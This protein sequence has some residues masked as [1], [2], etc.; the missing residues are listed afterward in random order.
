MINFAFLVLLGWAPL[1]LVL[2]LMLP[3]RRAVVV[4]AIAGSLL[5]PPLAIDFAGFPPYSKSVAFSV[6]I[7]LGTL[8]FEFDRLMRFRLRWF[9]L[10]M[11]LWCV[12]PSV[13]SITNGFGGLEPISTF[14]GQ[15][16]V[17]LFPYLIGR[18][19]FN[20]HD[21]VRELA[22][23][24]IIGA[25]CLIPACIFENRM[26]PLLLPMVYG[27]SSF[28]TGVRMGGYRPRVF[29]HT[30]LELGLWM[31]A[32]ALAAFW[33]WRNKQ[34][35]SIWVFSGT[36]IFLALFITA[37]LCRSAGATVLLFGGMTMLWICQRTRTN[38]AMWCIL[39]LAPTYFCVRIP[40]LWSGDQAVALIKSTLGSDRAA[41]LEYRM[42]YENPF[43]AHA[44]QRPAF[45]WDGW[46][47]N[48]VA[49][50][51]GYRPGI[52]SL[53]VIT[54]G[55]DGYVGLALMSTAMLL[56]VLL[57]LVRYP[58]IQW[59]SPSLAPAAALAVIL[60][61]F[62]I[63]CLFNAQPNAIYIMIAGGLVGMVP[64]RHPRAEHA[65][66]SGS[67]SYESLATRYLAAGRAAK[68]KG[69]LAEAKS[70][71]LRV[72]ELLAEQ[73]AARPGDHVIRQQ[74][75][76][77]ANDLAW[78]LVN[79][80]DPSV[81]DISHGV[82]LAVRA[83]ELQPECSTYWNTLGAAY[84]RAGEFEAAVAALNRAMNFGNGG[85]VF[86]HVFLAAAHSQLGNQEQSR[87]WLALAM[88]EKERG[89]VGHPELTRLVNEANS[90]V[91]AGPDVPAVIPP[92]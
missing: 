40:N 71:W 67:T 43:I 54:F 76:D 31:N 29:F 18:L 53:W 35:K 23:G 65:A 12:S 69:R 57:F 83:T 36:T 11:L 68:E 41:S 50:E 37:V 92:V 26:S 34:L 82:S 8:F 46:G 51:T 25:M 70:T 15:V 44:L 1:S 13:S 33:L 22:M 3:A 27:L 20:E 63:D 48:L 47:R 49:D 74:W 66:P 60:N 90:I 19:Y 75:C 89:L 7:L 56:P 6:G 28:F 72:L 17:W 91:A 4:G 73:R 79:A 78:L 77:C 9:D 10:P 84:Y 86:D 80:T 88:R 32:A 5:M 61:L 81:R 2:F 24:M 30:G 87:H 38:W 52:D 14:L 42:H 45:G 58:A 21:G 62:L 39:L 16:S 59:T 85:N 55:C 64:V